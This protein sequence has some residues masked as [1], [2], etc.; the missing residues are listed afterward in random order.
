MVAAAEGSHHSG[1]HTDDLANSQCVTHTWKGCAHSVQGK[2][3]GKSSTFNKKNSRQT[4]SQDLS[5]ISPHFRAS[6]EAR[7]QGGLQSPFP[8][9]SRTEVARGRRT[10]T[11]HT[12]VLDL[13]SLG[14]VFSSARARA[15][16]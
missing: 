3:T 12:D 11:T 1:P 4:W 2:Q 9:T 13:A 16:F 8:G 14:A 10:T 6:K 5:K 15:G 7:I